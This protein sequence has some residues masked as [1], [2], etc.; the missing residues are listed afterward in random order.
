VRLLF[1][2]AAQEGWRVHHKD[3]KSAFLND[4]LNEEVYVHQPSGF[5]IP[6]KEGKVLRL[7]KT[8]YSLRQALRA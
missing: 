2:L 3:V 6:D 7:R 4:N 1:A 8:L 5:V